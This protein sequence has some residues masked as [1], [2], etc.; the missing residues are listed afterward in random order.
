MDNKPEALQELLKIIEGQQQLLSL[1]M[2]VM[3][4]GPVTYA[5][6]E[7]K[8]T[9][10]H[11]KSRAVGAVALGAGQS[12]TNLVNQSDSRGLVVRD[13]YPIARSVVESFI[14]GAFFL[15]QPVHVAQRAFEHIKFAAWRQNNR[16]IGIGDHMIALGVEN[17]RLEAAKRFPAFVGKGKESWTSLDAVS[18]INKIGTVDGRA[19][20]TLVGAYGLIYA[21]SSEIIHGSVYGMSYFFSAHAREPSEEAFQ[22][23][24]AQQVVDILTAVSHASCGFLF[25]FA[26]VQ[27]FEPLTRDVNN[28]YKRLYK[29]AVGEELPDIGS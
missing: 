10:E 22:A 15:T 16:V 7:L 13:L 27:Q 19:A 29:V 1:S 6:T 28:R 9:L 18:R 17:P 2:Y 3:T 21:A 12:L 14:N 5:D 4:E 26:S 24:T 11:D 25:A 8:C 20:S 23:G